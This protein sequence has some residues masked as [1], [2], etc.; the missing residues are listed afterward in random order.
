MM[1]RRQQDDFNDDGDDDDDYQM[2]RDT[3]DEDADMN[4]AQEAWPDEEPKEKMG[5]KKLK[6][7]QE[8]AVKKER[9]EVYVVYLMT[10]CF[11]IR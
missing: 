3:S 4:D 11:L 8:K 10:N 5:T 1:T 9:R 6:K 2:D 7:L